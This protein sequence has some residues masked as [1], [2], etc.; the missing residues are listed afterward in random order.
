MKQTLQ[1]WWDWP[2]GLLLFIAIWTASLRLEITDWTKD[3]NRVISLALFA[4]VL[5]FLL[6]KSRFSKRIVFFYSLLFTIIVIPWSLGLTMDVEIPWL[7]RLSSL[8]GRLWTTYDQFAHNIPVED[9]LLFLTAMMLLYWI[10]SLMA[11]YHM[12]RNGHPWFG[13]ALICI[14]V[15]VIE[16]YDA[17][18]ATRGLFSSFFAI[19]IVILISRLY[20]INLRKRWEINGIPVDTE[21]GF[22]WMRS[23]L[24]VGFLLVVLAWNIPTWI[25]ALSPGTAERREVL[26]SWLVMREKLS[27]I[28][29][30]LSGSA[31]TEGDYYQD[32]LSLGTSISTSEEIVFVVTSSDERSSGMRYYWRARTYD[33]YLNGEW[34]STYTNREEITPVE[35]LLPIP[36]WEGRVESTFT[37][38][39]HTTL[40]RNFFS[41]GLPLTISRPAQAIGSQ[42]ST[43][44]LDASTLLAVPPLRAGEVY[45]IKASISTPT[46]NDL[47]TSPVEY[48]D[49]VVKNYLQL[50]INFPEEIRTLA[51][52]ITA[53]LTTPFDKAEAITDYLR[54]NIQYTSTLQAAPSSMDPMAYMLF[55]TKKGFC[56]Y[57]ASAEILMLRSIGIPARLAVGFAEGEMDDRRTTFTVRRKDAHAWPEVYF[58]EFGWVEF[59]PTVIQS[60]LVRR[61][62]TPNSTASGQLRQDDLQAMDEGDTRDYRG[63][64][65]AEELLNAEEP[66]PEPLPSNRLYIIWLALLVLL[67][68][69]GLGFFLW[70]RVRDGKIKLPP[71]AIVVDNN[72][73]RRGFSTPSW[74]RERARLARLSPL[75]QAFTAVPKALRLLG[76]PVNRSMT[77]AEQVD[78]LLLSLPDVD[79]PAHSLL[80]ELHRGIYSPLPASL[81]IA[82]K[83]GR[84][85]TRQA[86]RIK[87]QRLLKKGLLQENLPGS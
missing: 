11:G 22:D 7:E 9:P 60:A 46:K 87:L 85:I 25:R 77:P 84:R 20:Y 39:L 80:E 38:A 54:E 36:G 41:P 62:I 37:F 59:E 15:L 81:E 76:K 10:A 52:E 12:V 43:D 19:L 45:R 16:Y 63:E 30:P 32:D 6:G 86:W 79:G 75:E 35:E 24:L 18:R 82:R 71:L 29:A 3:L 40:I 61:E 2:A 67:L 5:G 72:L 66:T 74:I 78:L 31:P 33:K 4:V 57:Y 17:P 26:Q 34:V 48:P 21:T 58:D 28:I 50:P 42:V 73:T 51:E 14:T 27:N 56:Y 53:G 83:S 23:V 49:W 8:G 70:F 47:E 44:Y 69:M 55:V 1:R 13:L 64:E 65:R 68:P